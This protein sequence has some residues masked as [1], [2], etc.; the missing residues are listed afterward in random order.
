MAAKSVVQLRTQA[1][2]SG[3]PSELPGEG[4]L[5]SH[6]LATGPTNAT[7]RGLTRSL[8]VG[9]I[10]SQA[11]MGRPFGS[12]RAFYQAKYDQKDHGANNGDDNG[13]DQATADADTHDASQP[14]AYECSN[15]TDDDIDN[16][17]EAAA[18]HDFAGQPAG[19]G[20]DYKPRN[21]SVFHWTPPF[22]FWL[23]LLAV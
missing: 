3:P 8:S 16:Q 19:Y 21:D 5:S 15:D 23:R 22:A 10:A 7:R 6:S 12:N 18:F 20:A 9:P 14:A 17:T 1:T 13:A 2:F 11:A 4:G